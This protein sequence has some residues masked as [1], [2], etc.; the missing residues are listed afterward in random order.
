MICDFLERQSCVCVLRRCQGIV[1][2][3]MRKS[4]GIYNPCRPE[5]CVTRL[6]EQLWIGTRSPVDTTNRKVGRNYK[7][8]DDWLATVPTLERHIMLLV[9]HLL[10]KMLRYS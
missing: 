7:P 4:S 9:W 5:S 3:A 10:L 1:P 2:L 6:S 8:Y